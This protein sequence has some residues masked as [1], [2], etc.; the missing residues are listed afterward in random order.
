[1]EN[2]YGFIYKTTNLINNKIYIG[3]RKRSKSVY[4]DS[5]Y[6]G[7]GNILTLAVK[8][9]G[10]HNFKR[11][12]LEETYSLQDA[13]EKEIKWI[14]RF[15]STDPNIGYNLDTGGCGTAPHLTQEEVRQKISN[16]LKSKGCRPSAEAIEKS[17]SNKRGR[18]QRPLTEETKEKL[19]Q[20]NLGKIISLEVKQKISQS[21]KGRPRPQEV[22]DRIKA[23]KAANADKTSATMKHKWDG[24]RKGDAGY[25][26]PK[27][28]PLS[29]ETK[30]KISESRKRRFNNS[31]NSPHLKSDL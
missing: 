17:A 21:L 26:P 8:K 24:R 5:I 3:Q 16:T 10:R 14:A 31:D 7:S 11:E 15:N 22:I 13:N 4:E 30:R 19:R 27:R 12:I 20:A 6:L 23:T 9:Y 2:S 18:P 25:I 1:M 28:K 29:E